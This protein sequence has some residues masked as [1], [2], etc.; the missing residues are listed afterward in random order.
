MTVT[1]IGT[2]ISGW[3]K[4]QRVAL[5]H[6][7]LPGA[8]LRRNLARTAERE[9]ELRVLAALTDPARMAIDVG[10]NTGSYTAALLP[11]STRVIAIEPHPRLVR[12][13]RAFPRGRVEVHRAIASD[14]GGLTLPLEV[15][16]VANRE[17][18]ALGHVATGAMRRGVR[19]Y[20]T[21]TLALD[22]FAGLPVGFVKI[23]VE[24]HELAV[25]QGA[26]QLLARQRPVVLVE[27]ELRH[28]AGAPQD[29]FGYLAEQGYTGFFLNGGTALPVAGF[30]PALQDMA[31]LTGYRLREQARYVN[32]FIFVPDE[33]DP[34]AIM[35]ACERLL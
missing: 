4:Q 34:A 24:G 14:R 22:D 6:C 1:G 11:L 10:A 15:E 7:L 23:D 30:S 13:L 19:R 28:R 27:A 29:V 17:A 8:A 9:V 12:L 25:L 31:L 21:P 20:P 5:F 2:S 32:N 16:L 33:R 18:D 3:L 26:R 35:A